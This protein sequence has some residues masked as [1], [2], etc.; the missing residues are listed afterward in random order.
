MNNVVSYGE[1]V[2]YEA[3]EIRRDSP[4]TFEFSHNKRKLH[5]PR[6]LPL[7][8]RNIHVLPFVAIPAG[9]SGMVAGAIN[10]DSGPTTGVLPVVWKPIDTVITTKHLLRM[11][12]VLLA[13]LIYM[14]PFRV[15]AGNAAGSIVAEQ[16]DKRGP[17]IGGGI[18]AES[19][20]RFSRDSKADY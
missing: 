11:R 6:C 10:S 14:W 2:K 17:V 15:I 19:P 12:G 18:T 4:T 5:T 16:E 7:F 1:E 9:F 3:G 20:S 8:F 13:Y